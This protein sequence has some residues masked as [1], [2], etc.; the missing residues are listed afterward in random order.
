MSK[1][2]IRQ[3]C[4]LRGDW[5][6]RGGSGARESEGKVQTCFRTNCSLLCTTKTSTRLHPVIAMSASALLDHKIGNMSY[7]FLYFQKISRVVPDTQ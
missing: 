3:V 4:M 7:L 1:Y 6:G 5:W 2:A